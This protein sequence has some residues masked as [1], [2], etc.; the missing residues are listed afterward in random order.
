MIIPKLSSALAY[1]GDY[2]PEQWPES[3][4]PED[5]K[6][7]RDAGVNL[8]TL[9]V[10]SWSRLQPTEKRYDFAWLDRAMDLL[11][12]NGIFVDLATATASP[13]PW[14]SH[15]YP[16]V[17]AIDANGAAWHP[18]SRQHYSPCSPSY[19]RFAAALV[20]RIAERYRKHPALAAWH[21]NNEYGNH[22]AECHGPHA[23]A[24]F[25]RWLRR[26]YGT[27]AALN[28]AWGTAFW[29][30]TYGAWDEILTPRRTPTFANPTQQLD[31][32]RF[33]SDAV[34][35]LFTL[36]RDLV[37]AAAP[38]V[39]VTTNY[40]GFHK[41]MNYQ[42][43]S[44]GLDFVSWDSYPDPTPGAGGAVAN[45]ATHD[46]TRSLKK[47]RPF[48]LMEQSI[49]SVTWRTINAPKPAG[50][51]RLWS[52]QALAR[53]S[54]GVMFFQWRA[55]TA[56]A[57]KFLGGMVPHAPAARS[58]TYAEVKALGGELRKLAPIAG[59]RVRAEVAIAFDWEAWWAVELDSKPAPIAYA[60]WAQEIHAHF[61]ARNIA[62]DFVH[63]AEPLDDYR[64]VIAP[65]LYLLGEAGAANLTRF[66]DRGGQL[67][68]TYFSGIVDENEHALV[69]GYPA[70]LREVLGLWVEEWLPLGPEERRTVRFGGRGG[71]K[72]VVRDWCE[73]VH[74]ER[75]EVLARYVDG[76]AAGEAAITRQR[77]GAGAAYYLSTRPEAPAL[78]ALLDEVC[79]AGGVAP[80]LTA[81][82]GV[83]L[84]VREN[85]GRRFMFLLNHNER[86]VRVP[87]RGL[88]GRDLV[89]AAR[90]TSTIELA[91]LGARAIEL[92]PAGP[93]DL[94]G[95]DR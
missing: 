39:P 54:D 1:G 24:A 65:A 59:S 61:F 55:S 26:R 10:F 80:L 16:D 23:T 93:K 75:A 18:G 44:R 76:A 73:V 62:V 40:M 70:R 25:R 74:P 13:P 42:R 8:V 92:S 78:G 30:Q 47:D 29:S 53:G 15:A 31:Y 46:L 58:R 27:L 89:T 52:W 37:R 68:A 82:A 51:M 85:G 60:A 12:A 88:A 86:R 41:P 28:E 34:L 2:N 56:G 79:A 45:A 48:L 81:P 71:R 5:M 43:W 49:S 3:V 66:V 63:P 94:S 57:E 91:P 35:E 90:V 64:V 95:R 38:D 33:M 17:L 87:L 84:A 11:G 6:L 7:M 14:L 77:F 69:G 21:I 67:L 72:A 32:K 9:G 36:E 20:G 50:L 83:E 19:R 22:V 4:W